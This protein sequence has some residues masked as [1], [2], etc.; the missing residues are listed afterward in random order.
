MEKLKGWNPLLES[1]TFAESLMK[2]LDRSMEK[3]IGGSMRRFHK[4][5]LKVSRIIA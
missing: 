4:C 5:S 3:L 2:D 1:L